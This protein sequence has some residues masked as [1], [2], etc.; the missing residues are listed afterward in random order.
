LFIGRQPNANAAD[1]AQPTSD[2]PSQ[3]DFPYPLKG[4]TMKR[5]SVLLVDDDSDFLHVLQSRCEVLG[6]EVFTARN[7]LTA[8]AQ[9][10]ALRPDLAC[11][12]VNMPTGNGIEFC[13]MLREDSATSRIPL[14]ILTGDGS[15]TTQMH[16]QRLGARHVLKRPDFW[17]QL[18]IEFRELLGSNAV[19][20]GDSAT[21]P[22]P[23]VSWVTEDSVPSQAL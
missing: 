15:Q 8:W 14:V 20:T 9:A 6:L 13:E 4:I 1:G 7:L 18:E 23:A 10:S 11:I 22:K 19:T 2:G 16:C 17:P 12:D 3:S 21:T 5:K